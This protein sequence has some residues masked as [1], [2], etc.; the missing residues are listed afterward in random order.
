VLNKSTKGT[1]ELKAMAGSL[2]SYTKL[3]M[4]SLLPHN[5]LEYRNGHF[6]VDGIDS[7]GT[8][9]RGQILLNGS[10][11]SVAFKLSEL[12]ELKTDDARDK[13]RGKRVIY[14]YHNRIDDTGDKLSSEHKVFDAVKS[15]IQDIDRMINR[16]GRSLNVTKVIV[17]SDHGFIYK[18]E[19]L[20]SVDKLEIRDIDRSKIIESNKRF[21]LSEQ[22]ITLLNTHKFSMDSIVD[23]DKQMH[24]YVPLADLRFKSQGGGVNYVHGGASLQEIVIPVLVYSHN[25]YNSDL[26][27]KGIEHGKVEVTV[28]DSH[29]KI[30][31]SPFK[32]RLFQTGKVTD[33][34]E[35]L[36]C[37]IALWDSDGRKVSDEKLIIADS[38]SDEAKDR[39][40]EAVL[41]LSSDIENKTYYLTVIDDD[42]KALHGEIVEIPI[43]VD[44]LIPDDF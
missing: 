30:T 12:M 19:K 35:P 17:T 29:K 7:D 43:E 41:T 2:P 26:D 27:R 5:K 38:T 20:E 40:Y 24:L 25:K 34:R 8:E 6:F 9:N 36:N 39:I 28:L 3:G 22:D 4:A 21:I 32:V 11:D 23:S 18:R 16:L 33:K 15:S 13:I 14:L 10:L 31:S 44:I 42:P 1:M 37:K